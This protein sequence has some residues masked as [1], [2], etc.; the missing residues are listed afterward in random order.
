MDSRP[1]NKWIVQQQPSVSQLQKERD[2]AI[3][4]RDALQS[5]LLK[6]TSHRPPDAIR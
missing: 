6:A 4:Q 1:R 5:A 2:D 3:A